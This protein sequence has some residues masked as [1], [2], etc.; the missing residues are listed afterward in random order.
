MA[1]IRNRRIAMAT[2]AFCVR[3]RK[4]VEM[5]DEKTVRYKNGR[6]AKKGICPECQGIVCKTIPGKGRFSFLPKA[7]G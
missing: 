2:T 4:K 1:P 3:C 5:Q 7:M 6:Y